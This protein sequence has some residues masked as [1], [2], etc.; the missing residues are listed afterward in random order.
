MDKFKLTISSHFSFSYISIDFLII[1][2]NTN[3]VFFLE[4]FQGNKKHK[5]T[6]LKML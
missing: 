5:I 4:S 3:V 1:H 2:F 6:K